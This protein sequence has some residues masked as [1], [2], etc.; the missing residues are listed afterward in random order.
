MFYMSVETNRQSLQKRQK[1]EYNQIKADS[2]KMFP[3]SS[4]YQSCKCTIVFQLQKNECCVFYL[5]VRGR[6]FTEENLKNNGNAYD[7]IGW[8]K[9]LHKWY[10][11]MHNLS[12]GIQLLCATKKESLL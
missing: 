6:T 5:P 12:Y 10:N 1:R 4:A 11:K 8:Q 7:S 3:Q 9:Q 2:S